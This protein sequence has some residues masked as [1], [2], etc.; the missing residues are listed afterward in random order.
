MRTFFHSAI[1]IVHL[2]IQ[3]QRNEIWKIANTFAYS[4]HH[5]NA[6]VRVLRLFDR[7]CHRFDRR[8]SMVQNDATDGKSE[9]EPTPTLSVERHLTD[10]ADER[11]TKNEISN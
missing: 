3:I 1:R 10:N 9:H 4:L 2:N 7:H 5:S 6:I 11:N 8:H